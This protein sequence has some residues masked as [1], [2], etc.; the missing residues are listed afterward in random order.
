MQPHTTSFVPDSIDLPTVFMTVGC[1][2]A[3]P[4][5]STVAPAPFLPRPVQRQIGLTLLEMLISLGILGAVV[6]GLATMIESAADDT[7]AS[8]TALH[9]RTVGNAADAYIK[10]NYAAITTV[11][12]AA[13]PALIRVA[14][15]I[16]QGYLPSGY[17][18]LNPRGQSTCVLVLEPSPNKLMGLLI[19]EGGDTIDDLTLGQVAGMVGGSGAG[20]YSASPGIIS[21][22]M[23]SFGF[24]FGAFGNPNQLGQR[25]DGTAG[26]PVA[27]A[28]HLAMAL[29]YSDAAQGASTL[30]RDAVPGNPSLNTMNTPILMGSSTIQTEGTTCTQVGLIGR[31]ATGGVLACDNGVWAASGSAF[32][33]DP[34]P[35]FAALPPC[36]ASSANQTRVVSSPTTGVGSRAYTCNGAGQWQPLAI[37]DSG[38][39]TV[40]GNVVAG[41]LDGSLLVIPVATEGTPCPANGRIAR[42]ATGMLLSCNSLVWTGGGLGYGQRWQNVSRGFGAWYQNTTS[43]PIMV[44]GVANGFTTWAY[45]V[46]YISDGSTSTNA[47]TTCYDTCHVSFVVPPNHSYY[48]GSSGTGASA[49][50]VREL[51]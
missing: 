29:W 25:C 26:S 14:D 30:Y 44:V 42:A 17:S 34:V 24:P 33:R 7:K 9:T 31:N 35:T 20:V 1:S 8:V 41:G 38:T 40:P 4:S 2:I 19:T 16:A 5:M 46:Y 18:G 45:L 43:K 21:G 49:L 48:F 23:G 37:S 10:D 28:G 22:A 50:S 36:N 12:S 32:W 15:L 39:L 3:R 6:V 11:A 27:A 47:Y 51:R 13:S